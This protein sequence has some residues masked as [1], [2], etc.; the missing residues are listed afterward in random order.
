MIPLATVPVK[1]F[2]I[3]Y[4]IS[5]SVCGGAG[6]SHGCAC[7][8]RV[9]AMVALVKQLRRILIVVHF[10]GEIISKAVPRP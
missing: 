3:V 10:A 4:G 1:L 5:S 8:S 2:G 9:N 6:I 7:Q